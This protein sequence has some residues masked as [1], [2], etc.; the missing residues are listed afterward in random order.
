MEMQY[1]LGNFTNYINHCNKCTGDATATGSASVTL[2]GTSTSASVSG[3]A[4]VTGSASTILRA[5]ASFVGDATTIGHV[6]KNILL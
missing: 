2:R 1:P 3:D 6:R 5:S 4:T